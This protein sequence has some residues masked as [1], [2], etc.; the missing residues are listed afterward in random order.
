[1]GSPAKSGKGD[2]DDDHVDDHVDV[3]VYGDGDIYGDALDLVRYRRCLM[4]MFML[5]LILLYR[6]TLK[7]LISQPA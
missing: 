5:M 1:M 7:Q 2:D 6:L 3:Y 4:L